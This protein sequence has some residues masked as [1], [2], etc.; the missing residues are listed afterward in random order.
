M[1]VLYVGMTDK[2]SSLLGEGDMD[3]KDLIDMRRTARL[4]EE[5]SVSPPAALG[6]FERHTKVCTM[7][8]D[9]QP[10]NVV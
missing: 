5:R 2:Y 9:E 10:S 4:R 3:G 7:H 1:Y 6:G 8:Q